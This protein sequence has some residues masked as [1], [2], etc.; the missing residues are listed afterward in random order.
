VCEQD[1]TQLDSAVRARPRSNGFASAG[2]DRFIHPASEKV[3]AGKRPLKKDR[4]VRIDAAGRR[5][6]GAWSN[7]PASSPG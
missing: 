6:T 3:A 7:A 1:R 4:F 5:W 2:R